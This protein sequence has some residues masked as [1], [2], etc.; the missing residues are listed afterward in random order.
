MEAEEE[1]RGGEGRDR[2]TFLEVK[3]LLVKR[4]LDW[5][6]RTTS[7]W[8]RSPRVQDIGVLC[9]VLQG[10]LQEGGK[11]GARSLSGLKWN[12]R[13]PVWVGEHRGGFS[14]EVHH[15]LSPG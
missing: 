3:E 12:L 15:Y 10:H 7:W 9:A 8:L 2:D 13:M 6:W 14:Y 1:R 5:V 4:R 11:D